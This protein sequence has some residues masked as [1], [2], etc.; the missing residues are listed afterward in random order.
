[1]TVLL[2]QARRNRR[3][4]SFCTRILLVALVLLAFKFEFESLNDKASKAPI[5]PL[6]VYDFR[7]GFQEPPHLTPLNLIQ[8][9]IQRADLVLIDE[10]HRNGLIHA[11]AWLT[12]V[13]SMGRTLVLQRGP[14]LVTCPNAWGLV[15][16]HTLGREEPLD[17]VRRAVQE[18]L[19]RRMVQ[20]V[21]F[22]QLLTPL[23]L[24]YFR[25]YGSANGNRI[26]RQAT[27]LYWVQMDQPGHKLPM[28]L[29]EEVADHEWLDQEELSIWIETA[30][31]SLDEMGDAAT[32]LCDSTIV[33]LWETVLQ[34]YNRAKEELESESP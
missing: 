26:D 12:I 31:K 33:S 28:H 29:D 16:E 27:Y 34:V 8:D 3:I 23:P 10:T 19:G 14:K 6:A 21:T 4:F 20:H 15:G 32:K 5:E 9:C 11:G 1:M 30:R 22:I 2:R 25:D 17:T 24:Y 13:D 18:E 7:P